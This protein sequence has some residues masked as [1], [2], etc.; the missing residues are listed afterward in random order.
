MVVSWPKGIKPDKKIRSQFTHVLIS[1]PRFMSCWT[2]RRRKSVNGHEQMKMDGHSFAA[3]FD[4]ADA[5]AT[6]TE[7]FFDNNGSCAIYKDGWMACAFGTFY[8]WNQKASAELM[9]TWDS[10]TDEWAA[11]RLEE[12]FFAGGQ[13]CRATFREVG[14]TEK[15]FP[16][17]RRGEQRL[18]H[19]R[20]QLATTSSEGSSLH[21]LPK[22]VVHRE[23]SS[24]A[25]VHRAGL[26]RESN[27]V[28]IDMECGEHASGVLYALGGSG[29]GLAVYMDKGHLVYL[30]NMM[31]IEQYEA[32]SEKP[33][34]AGK[35]KIVVETTIAGSGKRGTAIITVDGSEIGKAELKRTVPAA[36]TASESLDIGIDWFHRRRLL[37]REATI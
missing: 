10:A 24:H 29:G 22:M 19:R 6:N 3:T 20:R 13:P 23:H 11:L 18:S 33:I 31:I 17:T 5:P 25:R 1:P 12:R 30:Y 28:E 36:F 2:S 27:V 15:G 4:K 7:Q 21:S 26:G 34:A 8:P 35:H 32:R 16:Q 37:L 14:C 9:K